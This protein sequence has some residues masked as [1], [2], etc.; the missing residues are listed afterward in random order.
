[1]SWAETLFLKKIIDGKKSLVATDNEY[2]L[3]YTSGDRDTYPSGTE[4]A[5]AKKIKMVNAGSV[6][7]KV[8]LR[9]YSTDSY[10]HLLVYVNGVKK[11]GVS[12]GYSDNEYHEKTI[13]VTFNA[14]DVISF[15]VTSRYF[16]N[17]QLCAN[18]T[19]NGLYSIEEV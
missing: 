16:Q 17:L 4:T 5:M 19:D 18:I 12:S 7:V 1:M 11:G 13:D 3:L 14:G 8:S 10:T 15:G 9:R 2:L 6:R